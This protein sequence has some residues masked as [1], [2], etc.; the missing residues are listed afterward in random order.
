MVVSHFSVSFDEEYSVG[1]TPLVS[2]EVP[3]RGRM[4]RIRLKIE[5]GNQF[6]SI[7]ARTAHGLLT[8]LETTGR[9][10][11]GQ[12]VVESSSGNLGVA[13]AGLCAARGYRC[14]LVVDATAPPESVRRIAAYGADVVQIGDVSGG[15]AVRARLSRVQDILRTDSSAVWTD[16]YHSPANPD[17]HYRWTAPELVGDLGG[18][19]DA[20]AV[21]V[22][23]GGTLAGVSRYLREQHPGTRVIAVDAVGSAATGGDPAPRPFKLAGFGSGVRSSFLA[24]ADWDRRVRVD[25]LDGAQ[26]CRVLRERTGLALGG[27]G[28]AAVLGAV[29]A[30]IED[31]ELRDIACICADGGEKYAA[32]VYSNALPELRDRPSELTE[33]L[34][35]LG[36][37]RPY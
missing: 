6:G 10:S 4:R 36:L 2:V 26:A 27:S 8:T 13:L 5:A 21:A 25:D 12:R 24:P 18:G 16:Q 11:P 19:L 33:A 17:V 31:P 23:T 7:K 30:A 37:A 32:T 20:A 22:S 14:T 15:N 1:G 34:G 3:V 29:V 35:C 28:G 9:L